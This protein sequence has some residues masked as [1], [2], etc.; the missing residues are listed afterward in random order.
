MKLITNIKL[1]KINYIM[2]KLA[3]IVPYRDRK[4]H[5][6]KF[7]PH[8]E[9]SMKEDGIQFNIFVINQG[10]NK[11]FNRGK[12]LNIGFELASD[13]DYFAFHDVDMLP[14]DSDYSYVDCPTHLASEAEQFGYKLPYEGYFGGVTIFDKS[15]FKKINGYAN[16]YWGW[17]AEDDDVLHRCLIMDVPV[18]RKN[19]RYSSLDHERIINRAPYYKN[20]ERLALFQ[21]NPTHEYIM[22]DG[23]STLEYKKIGEKKLSQYSKFISVTL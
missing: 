18:S 17:G 14:V 16:E 20:L 13:F 22:G 9:K 2:E 12:L 10:D 15:S 21:K 19:C 3:I 1:K 7:I 8:M 6:K 11:D 5:L 4:E 23:L